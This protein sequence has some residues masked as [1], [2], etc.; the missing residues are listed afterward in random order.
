MGLQQFLK[1]RRMCA[2]ELLY[3]DHLNSEYLV[4]RAAIPPGQ[5]LEALDSLI[6]DGE[7]KR[8]DQSLTWNDIY[9]IE[10]ALAYYH[11]VESLR[12]KII[13]LR[14]NYRS[15]AGQAEF[16]D[17]MA[18]KPPDLMSPPDPVHPP[19]VATDYEGLLREDLKDLLGR[20]FLR[21][22]ILPVREAKLKGLTWWAAGLCLASLLAVLV[23]MAVILFFDG[24]TGHA[25]SPVIFVVVVSGAIGGFVSALQRIQVSPA[26]GDSFYSLSLLFNGSY[27]V[28]VAPITGGIFALILYLM[29]TGNV[30][31]GRFFPAIYTPAQ[32]NAAPPT[33]GPSSNGSPSTRAGSSENAGPEQTPA[34]AATPA[35]VPANSVG[36]EEFLQSGP[37]GGQDYALLILWC[38]IAGFAERFVPDALD[39]L[40]SSRQK[41]ETGEAK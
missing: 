19:A 15:I 20:I 13:R 32:S 2:P 22:A 25:P 9:S 31:E 36:I 26:D 39:R 35:P 8:A 33:P 7:S 4:M 27:A 28:F 40:I 30:L 21:Y 34:P 38:F 29:F 5:D 12:S 14:Y 3:F 11:P 10:L 1:L 16:D 17:Y 24:K 6:K 18:S 37:A 41:S 23:S